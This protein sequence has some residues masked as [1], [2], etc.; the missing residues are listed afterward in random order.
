VAIVENIG[1]PA[2]RFLEPTPI[3]NLGGSSVDPDNQFFNVLTAVRLS[4]GRLIVVDAG[5]HNV[6]WY[7][8]DGSLIAS[9]GGRGGGPGEFLR[10]TDAVPTPFGGVAVY[11]SRNQ[12]IMNFPRFGGHPVKPEGNFGQEVF[13]EPEEKEVLS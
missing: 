8:P 13:N 12:R 2:T 4:D 11:D 1:T 3:V 9:T 5:S 7:S 6:K 10:I